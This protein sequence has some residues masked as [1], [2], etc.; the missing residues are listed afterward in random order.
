MVL[1]GAPR[2]FM[3]PGLSVLKGIKGQMLSLGPPHPGSG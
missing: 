3:L 1:P 2:G